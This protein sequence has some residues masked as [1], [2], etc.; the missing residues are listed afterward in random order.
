MIKTLRL[1]SF[2]NFQSKQSRL[3]FRHFT[4]A[5]FL[6]FCEHIITYFQAFFIYSQIFTL[7][8]FY[9]KF[10]ASHIKAFFFH[11]FVNSIFYITFSLILPQTKKLASQAISPNYFRLVDQQ[12][13][14]FYWI[15]LKSDYTKFDFLYSHIFQ[16][17]ITVYH[18][19]INFDSFLNSWSILLFSPQRIFSYQTGFFSW[20]HHLFKVSY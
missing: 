20:F 3:F 15:N 8:D 4:F 1:I 14:F 19:T 16:F 18:S 9:R 10:Q 6:Y 12:N 17:L 2:K 5:P 13:T 7:T 11:S